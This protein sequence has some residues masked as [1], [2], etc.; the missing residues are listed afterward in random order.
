MD[1]KAIIEKMT[2]EHAAVVQGEIDRLN[3]EVTKA[4]TLL[5]TVTAEKDTVVQDL[6]KAKDD[7]K[8]ANDNLACAK[9]ELDTLKAG[10]AAFDEEEILKAMPEA[11]KTVYLK[12]KAQKEAAEETVRKAKE[13]EEEAQAIAKAANLKALPIEQTKLV[14]ILKNCSK[15]L[16]DVLTSVNAA[17][18]GVVLGEVG[19]SRPGAASAS[20]DAAWSKIEAKADDIIKSKGV[21]KAKAIAQAVEENPDLYKE[22]LKGGAN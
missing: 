14:G 17:M 13:T 15:E 9:S 5:A 10:G 2:Q 19:K 1:F 16:F 3:G 7:L 12:M 11:A 4:S 18:E 8:T 22:Y 21:S 6:A 20:S